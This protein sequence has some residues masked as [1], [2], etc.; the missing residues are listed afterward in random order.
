M[1]LNVPALAT[2]TARRGFASDANTEHGLRLKGTAT[3]L[4]RTINWNW[5]PATQTIVARDTAK[6]ADFVITPNTV[7]VRVGANTVQWSNINTSTDIT[8]ANARTIVDAVLAAVQ[9]KSTALAGY[10]DPDLFTN[11][12][13]AKTAVDT[14]LA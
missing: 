2:D 5:I 14:A 10:T 1:A 8:S 3:A 11:T 12:T 6:S 4:T 9:T 7:S 13:A